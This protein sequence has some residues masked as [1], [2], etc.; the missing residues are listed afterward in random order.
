MIV[1]GKSNTKTT[2]E[3]IFQYVY[4]IYTIL[5]SQYILLIF[6][7][8]KRNFVNLRYHNSGYIFDSFGL[9]HVL[10]WSEAIS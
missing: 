7:F 5:F 8:K 6:D 2:L 4:V 9:F 3:N 1:I 10:E